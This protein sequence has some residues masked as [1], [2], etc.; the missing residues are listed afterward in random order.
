MSIRPPRPLRHKLLPVLVLA[1]LAAGC[2]TQSSLP[3]LTAELSDPATSDERCLTIVHRL[4][5]ADIHQTGGALIDLLASE[6]FQAPY[7]VAHGVMPDPMPTDMRLKIAAH[8]IF[9]AYLK[10]PGT[11]AEKTAF[12]C[13][14]LQA[15]HDTEGRRI[16]VQF[17]EY[18][19][20]EPGAEAPL[21]MI[22]DERD[23]DPSLRVYA[24]Q[25]LLSRCDADHYCAAALALI[26][27]LPL[28]TPSDFDGTYSL[29]EN[30]YLG[31][32]RCGYRLSAENRTA[33][34]RLGFTILRA[35]QATGPRNGYFLAIGL[36]TALDIKGDFTPDQ[37]A[38]RFKGATGLNE[39]FYEETVTNALAWA[40]A[41][42][43]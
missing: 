13:R 20:W 15:R 33:L 43:Y 39:L 19:S 26:R 32:L 6:R 3:K 36:G 38:P 22:A 14:L 34:L 1:A 5:H 7:C 41:N 42:G 21:A 25:L 17:L 30:C 18:S 4:R 37:N 2:V 16:L 11:G 12:L 8:G 40:D 29:Q 9:D 24:F 31:I 27:T 23:A 10:G 35:T 28:T